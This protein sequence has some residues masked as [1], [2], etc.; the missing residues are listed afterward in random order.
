MEKDL[1]QED[2][3]NFLKFQ[4]ISL[5]II[6]KLIKT[7][8]PKFKFDNTDNQILNENNKP[9][10]QELNHKESDII[11]VLYF[12]IVPRDSISKVCHMVTDNKTYSKEFIGQFLIGVN[13]LI[14]NFRSVYKVVYERYKD[15][16][17][18]Y[19][20]FEISKDLTIFIKPEISYRACVMVKERTQTKKRK[21]EVYNHLE[22]LKN[23]LIDNEKKKDLLYNLEINSSDSN[24]DSMSDSEESS[25]SD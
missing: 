4:N 6:L 7:T 13:N 21:E 9:N 16:L 15:Q 11:Y 23:S 25:D 20:N 10:E 22:S 1:S 3:T 8:F 18:D 14:S 2:I 24:S 12:D 5:I 17:K 19:E